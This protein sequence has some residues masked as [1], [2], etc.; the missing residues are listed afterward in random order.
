VRGAPEELAI[1][2]HGGLEVVPADTCVRAVGME[3]RWWCSPPL[4]LGK[5]VRIRRCCGGRAGW[6]VLY[7]LVVSWRH[8]RRVPSHLSVSG[9]AEVVG[10]CFAAA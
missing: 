8:C 9:G 4:F 1:L 5:V 10:V 6:L 2:G 3:V 7:V